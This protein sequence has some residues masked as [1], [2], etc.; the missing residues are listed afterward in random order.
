MRKVHYIQETNQIGN[1]PENTG[2]TQAFGDE[3]TGEFSQ[4]LVNYTAQRNSKPWETSPKLG[5][6]YN[7]MDK[8]Y[9]IQLNPSYDLKYVF[10]E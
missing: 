8:F 1:I 7:A 9:A 6:L 5:K 10:S 2:T 3:P 4:K